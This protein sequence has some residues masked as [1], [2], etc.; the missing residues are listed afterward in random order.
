MVPVGG[1]PILWHIMK[2]FAYHGHKDFYLNL[3]YKAEIIKD[4]FLNYR[5]LNSDFTVDLETGAV[6]P[7][8]VDAAVWR[9]TLVDTGNNGRARCRGRAFE[10]VKTPVCPLDLTKEKI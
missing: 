5:E 10:C 4:Y 7:P 9:V 2:L 6:T 8:P 3:G 1:K